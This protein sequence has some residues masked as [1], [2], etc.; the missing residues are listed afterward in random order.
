VS[1]L[2]PRSG[3]WQ[4]ALFLGAFL[5]IAV[6][7]AARIH[8]WGDEAI[9][10]QRAGS[11]LDALLSAADGHLPTHSL[12]LRPLVGEFPAGGELPLRLIH[13]A[14]FSVGLIFCWRIA[15]SLVRS[16]W[17]LWWVMSLT[18]LLPNYLFY[19]TNI[20]M[21]ALLFAASMA[22]LWT[23]FRLLEPAAGTR[24]KLLAG[25]LA[26]ALV[27]ALVDFP[28]MLLV[29]VTWAALSVFHRRSLLAFRWFV[30]VVLAAIGCLA[31]IAAFLLRDDLGVIVGWPSLRAM[32]LGPEPLRAL[33]KFLFFQLRPLLDL[34][35]PPVYPVAV[36]LLLWLLP[37]LA[38]PLAGVL[39]WRR[40][41]LPERLVV[42]LAC[43]WVAG[44]PFGLAFTRA[45]LPAQFF[46][47]LT[48]VLALE[49]FGGRMGHPLAALLGATL[50]AVGLANLQQALA[51]T[52]RLYS[53]IP[54]PAIARD[55]V[56][57]SA[58][59][60]IPLIVI[61][62]HTL[63][64]LS[65][66]RFARPLLAPSQQLRLLDSRPS[67]GSFPRGT[68]VYVQLMPEDGEDSDPLKACR[69]G[70]A[71]VEVEPLTTYVRFEDLAYNRLWRSS[72]TDKAETSD[73]AAR[74]ALV[75]IGSPSGEKSSG[76]GAPAGDG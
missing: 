10:L 17:G 44:I 33:A 32:A 8:L 19:A 37:L 26:A 36:N 22:F 65:I 16:R 74:L 58:Q 35:Y 42:V 75:T 66:E 61:S 5:L 68:F 13:V 62:R 46:I 14:V 64:A 60:Q 39:L 3:R 4:P 53:R 28:G 76:P 70:V 69:G 2:P 1:P 21:Y 57:T 51:P 63:N 24:P 59:R 56:A 9:A 40:G 15:R 38:L 12:L 48:L 45:F 7:Y 23:A 41:G 55:A 6:R 47:L 27:C 52:L 30:P 18:I 54:Y 31:V 50:A 73:A 71:R 67:C 72:L 29:A 43:Y 34:V 11:G 25:H 49:R 20:R